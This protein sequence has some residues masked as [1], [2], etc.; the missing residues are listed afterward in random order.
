MPSDY[1]ALARI[2]CQYLVRKCPVSVQILDTNLRN[3]L[4]LGWH[5][6]GLWCCEMS[7][8]HKQDCARVKAIRERLKVLPACNCGGEQE[9]EYHA[10]AEGKE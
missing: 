10:K 4:I 5:D 1:Q 7:V 2:D 3:S 9:A 8:T 6:I